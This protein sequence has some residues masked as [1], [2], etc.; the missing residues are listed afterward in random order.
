MVFKNAKTGSQF[1][2]PKSGKSMPPKKVNAVLDVQSDAAVGLPP[3]TAVP[4]KKSDKG[5][6]MKG[7]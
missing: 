3:K 2:L 5:K 1:S 7:C 6:A 4:G